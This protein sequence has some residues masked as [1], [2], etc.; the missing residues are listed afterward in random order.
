MKATLRRWTRPD[1][2]DRRVEDAP[3]PLALGPG[4]D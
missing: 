4:A 3:I 2:P 1:A